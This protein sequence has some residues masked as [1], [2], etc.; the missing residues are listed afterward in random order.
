M[1]ALAR[2]VRMVG[3]KSLAWLA[4]GA[5]PLEAQQVAEWRPARQS[6]AS[7]AIAS[8]AGSIDAQADASYG[9]LAP[10][11]PQF[12]PR[13]MPTARMARADYTMP[14]WQRRPG[15][16]RP[17]NAPT[18]SVA[19]TRTLPFVED[20]IVSQPQP[21]SISAGQV[22]GTIAPQMPMQGSPYPSSGMPG[23]MSP[24][25]NAGG[26][27][28]A[29]PVYNGAGPMIPDGYAQ[30][31]QNDFAPPQFDGAC[32]GGSCGTPDCDGA[33]CDGCDMYGCDGVCGYDVM[34]CERFHPCSWLSMLNELSLLLGTQGFTGPL[35]AANAG[36]F[37]FHEGI[38]VG[39]SLWHRKGLGY[40]LGMQYIQSDLGGNPFLGTGIRQQ[41]FVTGGLFHR[42]YYGQGFQGGV[43]FDF[44]HD[45]YYVNSNLGQMRYELSHLFNNGH[46]FGYWGTSSN[47]TNQFTNGIFNQTITVLPMNMNNF[48]YRRTMAN[49]AQGRVWGGFASNVYDGF[50]TTTT[51]PIVGADFRMPLSNR[52]DFW[53]GFNYIIPTEGGQANGVAQSWGLMMSLA[54]YPAR[55]A[56]G[57]HNGP[58]RPLFNVA[59]NNSFML[60]QHR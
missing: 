26:M 14:D 46:E 1:N 24:Y 37:G 35:D 9:T 51:N 8:P 10:Q 59:D 39:D 60:D 45:N 31:M 7:A 4:L 3:R 32:A 22:P 21:D 15:A 52:V 53:G 18:R 6:M 47:R 28:M 25:P 43:V 11:G 36:N 58:Y 38:N 54:F 41:T 55:F 20:E 30:P 48:F 5:L 49:G 12:A 19:R 40:Q 29:P 33:P 23:A 50:T 17:M 44:L 42:A 2:R 13:Q 56:R 34:A 16:P 27:P 57:T